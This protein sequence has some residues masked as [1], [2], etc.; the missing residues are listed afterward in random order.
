MSPLTTNQA[1]TRPKIFSGSPKKNAA[2]WSFSNTSGGIKP[3]LV[4]T[5]HNT[6]ISTSRPSC[7]N[8]KFLWLGL[9]KRHMAVMPRAAAGSP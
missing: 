5:C 9:M 7:Q 2:C 6:K 1:Q 8:L 4:V 3:G